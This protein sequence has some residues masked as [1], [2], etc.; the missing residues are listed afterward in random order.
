LG[1]RCPL[2]SIFISYI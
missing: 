1:S 2:P